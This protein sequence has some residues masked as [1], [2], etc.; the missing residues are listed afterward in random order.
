MPATTPKGYPYPLGT[1]RVMDGDDSIK[2]LATAVDTKLGVATGGF[3]TA[4]DSASQGGVQTT[5]VTFPVGLFTS[6][7]AVTV[8][9]A[10]TNPTNIFI[11]AYLSTTTSVS[12][13]TLRTASVAG[14]PFYWIAQQVP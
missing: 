7:P 12:I 6:P 13:R 5:T 3:L 14:V 11:S 9:Q 2:A 4:P 1:D 10:T 8:A